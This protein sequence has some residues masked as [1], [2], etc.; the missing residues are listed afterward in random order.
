[1]QTRGLGFAP[2]QVV[3]FEGSLQPLTVKTD[4]A[5]LRILTN[6]PDAEVYLDGK[7]AG[8]TADGSLILQ[9]LKPGTAKVLLRKNGYADS[10]KDLALIAGR[11]I[12][13]VVNLSPMP[14]TLA[15]TTNAPGAEV[16]IDNSPRGRTDASGNLTLSDL[17][18]DSR[19]IRITKDG[20]Q[21]KTD[22]LN[23]RPGETRRM[24]LSLTPAVART[25]LLSISSLPDKAEVFIDDEYRGTTPLDGLRLDPGTR[26]IRVR[27]EGYKD[28][29]R[30]VELRT[31]EPRAESIPLERL[32]GILQF[33]IQPEG[34]AVKIG[35]QTFDTAKQ[36]QIELEPGTYTVELSAS[37]HKPGQRVVTVQGGQ[38]TRLQAV[39]EAVAA[40]AITGYQDSFL[41]LENWDN[42]P[43]WSADGLLHATGRGSAILK[44]RAYEDF[45]QR[46]QLRLN[47]GV[48]ASWIVRWQDE[49]NYC[50]IQIHSD[51]HT[52][53]TRR[54][55]IYFSTFRD[56]RQSAVHPVPL[57]FQFGRNRADW[58]DIQMEV[59]G[60]Q[61]VARVNVATGTTVSPT[62]MGRYTLPAGTAARGRIGFAVFEDEEFDVSSLVI[63]PI[64]RK[65]G[66]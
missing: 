13:H 21:E 60:D 47:K 14:A 42:P 53:R 26:K 39:L 8:T 5:V 65:P 25:A 61:I 29:E 3:L 9:D 19:A 10:Q 62:G 27:K 4:S 35:T 20:Y 22:L 32:L 55:T 50:L 33:N 58:V 46:F 52:D 54:N 1:V 66:Q 48:T 16:W 57:P 44:D 18:P 63:D 28:A 15:L 59:T 36:R 23:L 56:G 7:K 12:D 17:P 40:P 30:S 45:S 2:G 51:R 38:T 49:R 24:Q 43:G 41:G 31:G 64:P 11:A 37:G 6:P 34:A